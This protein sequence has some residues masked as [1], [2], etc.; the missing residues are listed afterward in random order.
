[1]FLGFLLDSRPN[2]P[3]LATNEQKEQIKKQEPKENIHTQV[4]TGSQKMG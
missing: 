3:M 4:Y 2:G 1:M